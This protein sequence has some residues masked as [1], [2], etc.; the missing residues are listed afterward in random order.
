MKRILLLTCTIILISS[1]VMAQSSGGISTRSKEP[2]QNREDPSSWKTYTVKDEEFSVKLPTLPS[3][4]TSKVFQ[5]RLQKERLERELKTSFQGV[6]YSIDVFEN[7]KPKQSL[8]E[9][10]AEQNANSTLDVATERNLNVNGFAG[11]EYSLQNKTYPGIVQFFATEQRLY[12][13]TALGPAENAGVKQFLSSI[14]LGKK[15]EGI[16]IADGPGV[17]LELNTGE[18]IFIGSE[19]DTKARL[20]TKPEPVFTEKARL[21]ETR[22]TVILR[23]VFAADGTVTNIRVLSGL[24]NGLTETAIDAAR[25]IRFVPAKK[26]GKPVSMWMQLEYNF[27]L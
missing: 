23:V 8:E 25:R 9:F 3:M 2:P 5:A 14:A 10:V 21:H 4:K 18:R 1:G 13:F 24:D 7:R 16:R 19:V 20:L 6:V 15:P 26:D 11:K 12:R 22:G 17:P 27:N